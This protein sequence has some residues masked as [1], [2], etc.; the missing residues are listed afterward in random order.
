MRLSAT[1]TMSVNHD[2]AYNGVTMHDLRYRNWPIL[3]KIMIIPIISLL[4]IIMGTEFV[5]MP[6]ITSWL[7]EQEKLKVKNVVEVAYQQMEQTAREAEAGRITQDAAKQQVIERIRQLRYGGDEYFWINDLTPRMVMHPTKPELDGTDLSDNKDPNGKYLFREFVKVCTDK[8]EGFVDYMWPKPGESKPSPKISYVKLYKPWGWIIGSGL[9]VDTFRDKLQTLH[10][11]ALISSLLFSAGLML[12]AWSVARGLKR[13]LDQGGRFAAAV[14]A[15][16]LTGRLEVDRRD[17]VGTLCTSLNDMVDGLRPMIARLGDTA[18]NLA[19]TAKEIGQASRTMVRSAEQQ[20]ADVTETSTA[21][22]DIHSLVEIVGRGVDG[23]NHSAQDSSSAVT[24]LA[25]SIEEVARNM[26]SLVASIDGISSSITDMAGSIKQIDTGVQSLT[27]T[28]TTTAASVL[29]FDTSIRQ[30]EAYAKNSAAISA[31]A[32]G[33][34]ETGK[35]AVDET[36]AGI[37]D[38]TSASRIASG[39]IGSLSDKAQ[40]IG[41]IVTVIDEIAQQT[42]LLALNASIIAAQAGANGKGFA[43]VAAEIKQ[44]AERT[45]R[46]TREI[47]D[48]IKGVQGETDRAVNAIAAVE[49]SIHNGERLSLKAG[50][51]LG[52]IVAGVEQTARQ[53]DEIA[54]A[55][56]EQA[57]GSEFIRSAM[58]QVAAMTTTIAETTRRQRDGSAIIYAEVGKMR[59]FSAQVMRSMQEQATVGD[60]IST[61]ARHVSDLSGQIQEACVNQNSGSLRIRHAVES[62]RNSATAVLDETMVVDKGVGHLVVTTK[63]LRKEMSVFKL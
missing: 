40:S 30:I 23:L 20:T 26:S 11:F 12:L 19:E 7:L 57:R 27:E 46:S 60:T 41:S 49:E 4:L 42:N 63:L 37:S 6:R 15:G 2:Y 14:A 32:L 47:A 34:A 55:T 33:D 50:E 28:S 1:A 8:G 52:K 21:A 31:S 54:R 5:I 48:T 58:D 16:D 59:E 9:Y 39:S 13:S 44:L 18:M 22:T 61:M 10:H 17:E 38:I 62:I 24:E 25:A 3:L 36:I 43:V 53:M 45:T 35:R 29:E 56:R 51:A